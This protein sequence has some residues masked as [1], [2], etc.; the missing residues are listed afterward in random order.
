MRF[1]KVLILA[2][3]LFG[4]INVFA[5]TNQQ[6]AYLVNEK[7]YT[8]KQIADY[9]DRVKQ[10]QDDRKAGKTPSDLTDEDKKIV[11]DAKAPGAATYGNEDPG[12]LSKFGAWFAETTGMADADMTGVMD[13]LDAIGATSMGIGVGAFAMLLGAGVLSATMASLLTTM[14]MDKALGIPLFG[15]DGGTFCKIRDAF[16]SI[17]NGCLFCSIFSKL[18]DAIN[19]FAYSISSGLADTFIKLL[20]LLLL[21]YILF[22]VLQAV[23]SFSEIDP[24]KFLTDLFMPVIKAIIAIIVL[25]DINGKFGG[26]SV[27]YNQIISPLTELSIGFSN[28]IQKTDTIQV[29]QVT[30]S[31][32]NVQTVNA[33]QGTSSISG[34][35]K[36]P[37]G[38]GVNE[39][40]QCFLMTISVSLVNY[41]S[42]GASFIAD[43][44]DKGG[45]PN[46]KMF[47]LGLCIFIPTFIIYL[48]FPFKLLDGIFQLMFVFALMPL[49]VI[50]WVLPATRDYSNKAFKMFMR[51]LI[52][53]ICLSVVMLMT[54]KILAVV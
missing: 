2:V 26:S 3:V 35:V 33:C 52:T 48:S 1:I 5:L 47:L 43:C 10:R 39:A 25:M 16:T 23:F 51:V 21:F 45:F 20:S 6:R 18:F 7:G 11:N 27:F 14:I 13:T 17:D 44:W 40:I 12:M 29:L 24:K 36:A 41:V 30:Q 19:T 50:L 22:K 53:F 49:W 9:E 15:G 34:G 54:L 42:M 4:S 31:G 37:L 38:K 46:V 32:G 28:E 8:A